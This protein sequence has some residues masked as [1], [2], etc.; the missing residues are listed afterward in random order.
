MK[1]FWIT[2]SLLV[3]ILTSFY[4][5]Q[6]NAATE[7]FFKIE[8]YQRRLVQLKNYNQQSEIALSRANSLDEVAVL[9]EGLNFEKVSNIHYIKV[10]KPQVAAK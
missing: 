10:I 6:V 8:N 4:I 7:A 5:F 1:S 2:T 9:T 3:I